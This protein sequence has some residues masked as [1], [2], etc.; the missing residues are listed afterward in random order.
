MFSGLKKLGAKI[1]LSAEAAKVAV[2]VND[3][4]SGA[5]DLHEHSGGWEAMLI[6]EGEQGE[7]VYRAN[8]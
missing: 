8:I 5:G 3:E 7:T 1:G 2:D 4:A 6:P